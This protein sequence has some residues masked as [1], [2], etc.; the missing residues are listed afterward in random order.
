L[1]IAK[2]TIE[3]AKQK[4]LARPV[5]RTISKTKPM[6]LAVAFAVHAP[7]PKAAVEID[8]YERHRIQWMKRDRNG[9]IVPR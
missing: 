6:A 5:Y 9:E 7:A 2:T 1:R 4:Y 3:N 8:H